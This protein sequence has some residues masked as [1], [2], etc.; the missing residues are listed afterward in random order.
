MKWCIAWVE[1][2]WL[3]LLARGDGIVVRSASCQRLAPLVASS[4]SI[5]ELSK[6]FIMIN[7]EDDEEPDYPSFKP[8]RLSVY[9]VAVFWGLMSLR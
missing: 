7:C 6:N 2:M 9:T 3:R 4:K 1:C 5:E 8:V